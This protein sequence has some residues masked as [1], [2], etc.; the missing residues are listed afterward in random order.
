M[1]RSALTAVLLA[2]AAPA[3]AGHASSAQWT[4]T[5]IE[6]T[7]A[8]TRDAVRL[9]PGT[10]DQANL[11]RF[12][13]YS[14]LTYNPRDGYWYALSDRGPGG[15]VIDYATRVQRL[16]IPF[17]RRNGRIGQP[18]VEK[19]ILFTAGRGETFNG[20]NPLLLN[21]DASKLG[22]SFDP[23]GFAI[24]RNGH[25]YVADE[26]GPSVYEF[27]PNGRFLRAF[28][29]PDNLLPRNATG[30]LDYVGDRKSVV[31]GRQDNRGFE[32]LSFNA[33]GDK[34]YA[35]MQDPLTQEGASN[36]GRRGRNV[37]IVE[38]DAR[39]G[40]SQA[41]YVYQLEP[42]AALNAIDPSSDDD[43]SATNQG[44]SIGLSAIHALSDREFLVLERDNRGLGVEVTAAPLHKRVYRISLRGASNVAQR[45]LAGS[46]DLP[47][48]VRPVAKA[49]E[50]D[51]LAAL[52]GA[53][54]RDIPEKLEGLAIG[55]RL[56]NGKHL[57]LIGSDNDYS[58]TQTGA[59]EQFEVCV[60]RGSGERAQVPL[61]GDCPS[62]MNRIPGTLIA[63]AV[64]FRR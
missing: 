51:I 62:G 34:L 57:V 31:S 22:M 47:A 18:V 14:D 2:C 39:S 26:Y 63:F 60:N 36:D 38:F 50:L 40:R 6:E 28:A 11:N 45:S 5:D 64:D 48:D 49:P 52:R 23:E 30:A 61:D 13:F 12:G 41:Q 4:L 44:R 20:L 53:G 32:G 10:P 1:I 35:V 15:G 27:A 3:F 7:P 59:G 46:N 37:R 24:G 56:R 8:T 19:T 17:D 21:G 25:F 54:A 55:P 42:I 43:F 33:S 29:T 16:R 58:V 9:P